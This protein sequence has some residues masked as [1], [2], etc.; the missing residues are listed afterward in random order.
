MATPGFEAPRFGHLLRHRASD[1]ARRTQIGRGLNYA[2]GVP[3]VL[4]C[5]VL[6]E[7][8]SQRPV[9]VAGLA[10]ILLPLVYV[11]F[12][13]YRLASAA[14]VPED[15][16]VLDSLSFFVVTWYGGAIRGGAIGGGCCRW[17]PG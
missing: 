9:V 13:L 14:Q 5:V 4:N 1:L 8:L 17:F 16:G 11:T 3:G 7:L 2:I 15:A 10:L 12:R 6:L